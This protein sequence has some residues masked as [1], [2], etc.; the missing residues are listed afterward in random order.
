MR[1]TE[2]QL[3]E[4]RDRWSGRGAAVPESWTPPKPAWVSTEDRARGLYRGERDL[5]EHGRVVWGRILLAESALWSE[6]SSA[7]TGEVVW[8]LDPYI[9]A[10]PDWLEGPCG[11]FWM[12]REPPEI[13]DDERLHVD[14]PGW[15]SVLPF[16]RA[17]VRP[18]VRRRRFPHLL[19]RSRVVYH[20]GV[21]LYRQHLPSRQLGAAQVPLVVTDDAERAVRVLPERFWPDDLVATWQSAVRE[22]G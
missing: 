1:R 21:L 8:S 2:A 22:R 9:D 14:V 19:S 15:S 13:S 7:G 3:Q 5:W 12:L 11:Q 6:G 10:F 16:V 17:E 18:S 20:Q 4:L